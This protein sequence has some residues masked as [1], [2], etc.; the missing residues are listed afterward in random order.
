MMTRRTFQLAAVGSLSGLLLPRLAAATEV[1]AAATE[2]KAPATA[3]ALMPSALLKAQSELAVRLINTLEA[4]Q[5]AGA[6]PASVIVSPASVTSALSIVAF[7]ADARMRA[8]IAKVLAIKHTD[9]EA[10]SAVLKASLGAPLADSPLLLANKLVVD[11]GV[12]PNAKTLEALAS[13][14]VDVSIEDLSNPEAV[15]KINAWVS[16][17]TKGLIPTIVNEAPGS[18]G[19]AALNALY[20]KDRWQIPFDAAYT[21]TAPMLGLNKTS[22]P[23]A[24]MFR[25]GMLLAREDQKSGFIAV[26]L[27]FADPRFSLVAA[28]NT[29]DPRRAKALMTGA[30]SWLGGAGF[31]P[32]RAELT[33]PR[34]DLSSSTSLLGPLNQMGLKDGHGPEA[35]GLFGAKSPQIRSIS[36]R[37]VLK[38]DEEGA[39]AAAATAIIAT[40]SL[41]DGLLKL[42][43]DRPF[44][45]ALRDTQ[46]GLIL[47]AG[48]V[49]K[50]VDGKAA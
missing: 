19:L 32:T 28:T 36:Q 35:L 6:A 7:G 49:A 29:K 12:E 43:F 14:G 17:K 24:M 5:K 26:D 4:G 47:L 38:L 46:S 48:Y 20:F 40:R 33:L 39:E 25:S 1:P 11:P 15:A 42:R 8:A 2:P 44:I 9:A 10:L 37:T 41:D 30:G 23:T 34:L 16:A 31:A 50:P 22:S 13:V 21:K 27:P 18:G 3:E 45:F